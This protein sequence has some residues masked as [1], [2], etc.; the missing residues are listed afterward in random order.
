MGWDPQVGHTAAIEVRTPLTVQSSVGSI[1]HM[2]D[3][4][5]PQLKSVICRGPGKDRK[6]ARFGLSL[7]VGKEACLTPALGRV[8]P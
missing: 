1:Q 7:W 2:G 6:G 8:K 4:Q 5:L 3:P